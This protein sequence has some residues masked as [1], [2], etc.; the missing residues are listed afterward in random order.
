MKKL[1]RNSLCKISGGGKCVYHFMIGLYVNTSIFTLT[2][3]GKANAKAV[4][5]CWYRVHDESS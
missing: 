1:N 4:V 2:P 3:F 5:E